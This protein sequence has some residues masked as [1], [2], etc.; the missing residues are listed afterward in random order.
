MPKF[1]FYRRKA[2]AALTALADGGG[3]FPF[4]Y[5]RHQ[6]TPP[7]PPTTN[8]STLLLR[9]MVRVR[10]AQNVSMNGVYL[11]IKERCVYK[12][13]SMHKVKIVKARGTRPDL[14]QN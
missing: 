7:P 6:I 2:T 10:H 1:N 4:S 11:S 13:R 14:T 12:R 5:L 3:R 9:Q 8:I